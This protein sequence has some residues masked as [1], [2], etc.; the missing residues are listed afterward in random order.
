MVAVSQTRKQDREV[1]KMNRIQLCEAIPGHY[2]GGNYLDRKS[3]S[4]E[5]LELKD[6]IKE[7]CS[8]GKRS[9]VEINKAL[10]LADEELYLETI[11][12]TRN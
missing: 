9:Y 8:N 3:V 6:K 5:T 7:L 10:H 4:K 1:I 12:R 2:I 11:C